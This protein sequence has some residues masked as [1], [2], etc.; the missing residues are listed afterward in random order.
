MNIRSS[1]CIFEHDLLVLRCPNLMW[2]KLWIFAKWWCWSIFFNHLIAL[3]IEC[4]LLTR[5]TAWNLC[6][7]VQCW[8]INYTFLK[9]MRTDLASRCNVFVPILSIQKTINLSFSW[10]QFSSFFQIL[11]FWDNPFNDFLLISI[12][13]FYFLFLIVI[14]LIL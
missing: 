9:W 13:I 11:I 1:F 8:N 10:H 3:S 2:A 5:F 6:W 7:L 12:I 4:K 14:H